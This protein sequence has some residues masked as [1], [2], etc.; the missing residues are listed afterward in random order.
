[1]ATKR[2]TLN[3]K[4]LNVRTRDGF[5]TMAQVVAIEGGTR[6]IFLSGQVPRDEA[7]GCVGVGDMRAQII[8]VSECIR[9][10]LESVG[11]TFADISK[12]VTYVTDMEEYLKHADL[13]AKYFGNPLCTST[14]VQVSRL[15]HKDF[16]VE[17]DVQAIV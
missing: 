1:M 16:M 9:I 14:T 8:H 5:T 2:T 3:P 13:R 17:I 15:A 6:Q 12:T 4:G 11:A 10:G 7:G